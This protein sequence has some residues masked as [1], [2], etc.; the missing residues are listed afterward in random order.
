MM[1]GL[2]AIIGE[3]AVNQERTNVEQTEL[4]ILVE[5][6]KGF[7]TT[8]DLQKIQKAIKEDL[9]A[10]IKSS[11]LEIKC[12]LEEIK[13]KWMEMEIRLKTQADLLML[14]KEISYNL[15]NIK[16]FQTVKM[17]A[18]LNCVAGD[19]QDCT[20]QF[21]D[22][23]A[24]SIDKWGT[25]SLSEGNEEVLA[26][27]DK[28]KQKNPKN[29]CIQTQTSTEVHST[30]TKTHEQLTQYKGKCENQSGIIRQLKKCLASSNQ[31]FEA[32]ALV[33]QHLQYEREEVLKQRKELS[34][35][36]LNLRG[37]LVTSSAACEKLEKDRHELQAA[38]EAFVQKLNQQHQSD[39]SELEERLKQ[40]Y[41]AECEKLQNIC[42][43]EAEKYK[44]Q[45][46]EQVD[47]LNVT[48]ENFKLELETSHTEKIDELK[49][50]YESSLSELK[51]THESERETL[52]ASFHEKQEQLEEKIGE[53]QREND[54][55]NEKLKLEEQ[56]RIAKEKANLKTPQIMYLEQELE[57]L[58][59]VLEI[60]N[61]KLHQQDIK[62]LKM[63]KLVRS[64]LEVVF[65][66]NLDLF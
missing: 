56:K 18:S 7:G 12:V 44:A 49:K 24:G 10:E 29:S 53:L 17:P 54:A 30:E 11:Q 35:E 27:V 26:L 23:K 22:E 46:Q 37:E 64:Q 20:F 55:L 57:S 48:H 19:V 4:N 5:S 42:I 61:E 47:N 31:K 51:K 34:L 65:V 1:D 9:A 62:L 52:D 2:A 50:D 3:S 40:F 60:K 45:L 32:L 16:V 38:Y 39:L 6:K 8:L 14:M 28:G 59:A 33:I 25:N 41:T 58:K 43:E 63:E 15:S 66:Q 13:E 36:L 21:L